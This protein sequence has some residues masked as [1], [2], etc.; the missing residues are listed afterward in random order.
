MLQVARIRLPVAAVTR[1]QAPSA[2]NGNYAVFMHLPNDWRNEGDNRV[3]VESHSGAVSEVRLGRQ[4]ATS[5]RLIAAMSSIHFGQYGGTASRILAVLVGLTF[6]LLFGAGVTFWLRRVVRVR[7]VSK[8]VGVS[9]PEVR[10]G[11]L[12]VAETR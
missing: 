2:R 6:P 11:D 5:T 7:R 10:S 9:A 4:A 8:A 12:Y 1:I 3:L